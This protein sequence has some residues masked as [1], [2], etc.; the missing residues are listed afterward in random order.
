LGSM[1]DLPGGN[2]RVRGADDAKECSVRTEYARA[3]YKAE[4][5]S[6][7]EVFEAGTILCEIAHRNRQVMGPFH[8]LMSGILSDLERVSMMLEDRPWAT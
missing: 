1:R 3:L 7:D 5:A 4:T 2:F 8:P 6:R